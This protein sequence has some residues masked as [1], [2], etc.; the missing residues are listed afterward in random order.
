M[1]FAN[2]NV[3][4]ETRYKAWGEVRYSS[5][6]AP[7]NYTYTGQYSNMD[8]FGLMFY[9]ARWYDPALGRFAQADSIIPSGVQGLDRYAYTRNNPMKYIDASGHQEACAYLGECPDYTGIDKAEEIM[10]M[11][12]RGNRD[13]LVAAGIA[14][15]SQWPDQPIHT[16]TSGQGP[17][18]LSEAQLNTNYGDPV[19]GS[20][21]YGLG[22][23]GADPEDEITAVYGMSRRIYQVLNQCSFCTVQDKVI[24]AALAQNNGFTLSTV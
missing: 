9:N 14:V 7:T 20:G 16:Q 1:T 17:A 2:G 23:W 12:T 19:P 22:L 24:V 4:S 5:A 3:V 15:Q 18:Q 11:V 6:Y 8:D 21:Q 10:A 13:I